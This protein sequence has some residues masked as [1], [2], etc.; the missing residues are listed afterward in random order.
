M[1]AHNRQM[2]YKDC[3]LA[4]QNKNSFIDQNTY[5]ALFYVNDNLTSNTFII[6]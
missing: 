3:F 5:S 4:T 6:G 1:H 2:T